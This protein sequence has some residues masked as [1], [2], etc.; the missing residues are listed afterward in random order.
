MT[1][2]THP[3]LTTRPSYRLQRLAAVTAAIAAALA[4]WALLAVLER[5]IRH[6][7]RAWITTTLVAL[8]ISLGAP[9]AGHGITGADRAVLA[10]LHLLVAITVIVLLGR[11]AGHTSRANPQGDDLEVESR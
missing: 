7:R 11:T 2:L 8:V 3:P 6:P 5:T 9:L 10:C 1:T 4:A